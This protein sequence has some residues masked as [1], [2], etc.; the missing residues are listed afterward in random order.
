MCHWWNNPV[1]ADDFLL[2]I[3]EWR[4]FYFTLAGACATL[5]GLL[6]VALSINVNS[7]NRED[8]AQLMR[9]GRDTLGHF[10]VV[11]MT[12]LMFLVPNMP[13]IGLGIALLVIGVS[14]S[15]GALRRAIG[16]LRSN[17]VARGA[18][19]LWRGVA[20]SVAGGLGLTLVAVAILFEV[21]MALYL[22]VCVLAM[23]IASAITTAWLLLTYLR[24]QEV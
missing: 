1:M 14:W 22:L 3:A 5:I 9:L 21:D 2:R 19:P 7:L 12:S 13:A 16:F 10:L 4:T 24:G 20:L 11:M 6:F 18:L 17:K 8:N 15:I 23:L